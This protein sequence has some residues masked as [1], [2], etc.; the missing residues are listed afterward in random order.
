[1]KSVGIS[2]EVVDYSNFM[3]QLDLSMY[4]LQYNLPLH[5][6]EIQNLTN[7]KMQ[8]LEQLSVTQNDEQRSKNWLIPMPAGILVFCD[9]RSPSIKYSLNS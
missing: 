7:R 3:L 2:Q 5:V 6:L 1:M 9:S 4:L 8:S